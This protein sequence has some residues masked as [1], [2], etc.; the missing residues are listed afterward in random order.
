MKLYVASGLGNADNV[1]TAIALLKQAGH[2]ITYDWTTHGPVFSK[3]RQA[4]T[5][6][7]R[8]ELSGVEMA[9][10]VIVLLPGGRGTH[11]EMGVAL[12]LNKPC[13]IV[14]PDLAANEVGPDFCAFYALPNVY[15]AE[16]VKGA[17][18]VLRALPNTA[19][20]LR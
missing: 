11:V 1:K 18:Q 15:H 14:S 17:M 8:K 10:A 19:I 7:A 16:S 4:C 12:A 5:D 2:E 3:G 6:V 20:G 13:V 9:N